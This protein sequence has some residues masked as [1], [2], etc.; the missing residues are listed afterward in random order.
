M[1]C[2]SQRFPE[3]PKTLGYLPPVCTDEHLISKSHGLEN[4]SLKIPKCLHPHISWK[5]RPGLQPLA[6]WSHKHRSL[7]G[8]S[9]HR[10]LEKQIHIL[11]HHPNFK[12]SLVYGQCHP[13][14][15][16]WFVWEML[17]IMFRNSTA[18]IKEHFIQ[19]DTLKAGGSPVIKFPPHS[20]N[21]S[22]WLKMCL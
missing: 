1:G 2:L 14:N 6:L 20:K 3:L 22:L 10:N 18:I 12:I 9:A 19:R 13:S 8:R 15:R 4:P 7:G 11:P 5:T 21:I 17:G 16:S